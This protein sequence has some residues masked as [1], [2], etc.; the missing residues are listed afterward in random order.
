[1]AA[2]GGFAFSG[3]AGVSGGFLTGVRQQQQQQQ[4]VCLFFWLC[5]CGTPARNSGV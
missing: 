5:T 2:A 4:S 1:M 3:A